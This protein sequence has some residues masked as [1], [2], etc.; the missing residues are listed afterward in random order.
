[1]VVS[2]GFQRCSRG[3]NVTAELMDALAGPGSCILTYS[4]VFLNMLVRFYI[5]SAFFPPRNTPVIPAV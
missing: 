2:K 4:P 1:M 5:K 3:P